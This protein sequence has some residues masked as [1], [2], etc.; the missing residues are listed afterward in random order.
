VDLVQFLSD[1]LTY[2]ADNVKARVPQRVQKVFGFNAV[3][4]DCGSTLLVRYLHF[5]YA[6]GTFCTLLARNLLLKYDCVFSLCYLELSNIIH[7]YDI[8]NIVNW[9]SHICSLNKLVYI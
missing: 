1:C 5:L 9:G 8:D 2:A 3:T 6:T 7:K 4:W